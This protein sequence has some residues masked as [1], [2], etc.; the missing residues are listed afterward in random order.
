M[1]EPPLNKRGAN[2]DG[3]A[4]FFQDEHRENEIIQRLNALEG[5]LVAHLGDA[6][7]D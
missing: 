4:Q 1:M 2:W 7:D 3:A 5:R 6:G